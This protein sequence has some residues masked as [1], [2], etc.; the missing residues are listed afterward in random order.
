MGAASVVA[1]RGDIPGPLRLSCSPRAALVGP[2]WSPAHGPPQGC[3]LAASPGWVVPRM[4]E[5]A[6]RRNSAVRGCFLGFISLWS[7]AKHLSEDEE[8]GIACGCGVREWSLMKMRTT[9]SHLFF[10]SQDCFALQVWV[11]PLNTQENLGKQVIFLHSSARTWQ[12]QTSV[13]TAQL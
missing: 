9:V 12:N 5:A 1:Q 2:R 8:A 13:L 6:Q 3:R 4:E 10:G 7:N 11:P